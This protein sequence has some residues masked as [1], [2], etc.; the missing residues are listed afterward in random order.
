KWYVFYHRQTNRHFF[1]R[2]ACA[3]EIYFDGE[4]FH[5]AE[6]TSCGLNGG[7]LRDEG[8]YEARIA[9]HLY[10]KNGTTESLPDQQNENHPAF[11]QDGED[12]MDNPNQYISNMVDGATAGY[13]YFD[14]ASAKTISVEIRGSATGAFVVRD[15]RGGSVA[16]RIPVAPCAQWTTFSAPLDIQEGKKALYFTYEGEGAADFIRFSFGA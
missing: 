1:S 6:I 8:A 15:G 4:R 13:R 14:F 3:E 2:Q 7:P 11:T 16:A 9:C 5:Q 10:S 12:R